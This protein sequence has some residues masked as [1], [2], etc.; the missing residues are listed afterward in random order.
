MVLSAA[1]DRYNNIRR[2]EKVTYILRAPE[3]QHRFGISSI[4]VGKHELFTAGRD[5]TVR[6]WAHPNLD[7]PDAISS[8]QQQQQQQ[9]DATDCAKSFDEHV[10]WVN[11]I[12]L[13]PHHERM[14]SCSSD[15]TLKVWNIN[16]STRS[17][18]TL[19]AHTDYVK[20]LAHA[21]HGVASGSLDGHIYVWDLVTG[22]KAIELCDT[23]NQSFVN[24]KNNMNNK[25]NS[26]ALDDVHRSAPGTAA[27]SDSSIYCMSGNEGGT[28]LVS[29]STDRTISVWDVRVGERVVNLRGHQDSVRCL[30]LKHDSSLMLSGGTDSTVKLWDLRH[31]RCAVSYDSFAGSVWALAPNRELTAFLSGCRDGA[32]WYNDINS[33]A[34]SVV[35]PVADPDPRSNMVLDVALSP[36]KSAAWVS[37]TG[38]AVR[39][40]PLGDDA[41]VAMGGKPDRFR[42][43]FSNEHEHDN[44]ENANSMKDVSSQQRKQQREPCQDL[45]NAKPLYTIP[46]LP[47]IIA[48]RTMNDRRHVLTCDT[49]SE[50]K[51]WDITRGRLEKSLGVIEG[52]DIDAVRT[53]NDIEVSVP[54]WFHVDIRLGSL[55]VRLDKSIVANAEIYAVDAGLDA[56][57]EDVKV[58]IGEHVVIG[59]FRRWLEKYKEREAAHE[60]EKKQNRITNHDNDEKSANY[61]TSS[62]SSTMKNSNAPPTS[63]ASNTTSSSNSARHQNPPTQPSSSSAPPSSSSGG[64]GATKNSGANRSAELPQYVFPAHI[65]VVVTVD[66]SPVP[67][68]R[69]MVGSFNG[70]EGP[71]LPRWV[72]DLVRDGVG[73]C[74]EVV[75]ISFS[76]E[77]VEGC[78]LPALS[79][80]TLNAPRVLRIRKVTAYVSRELRDVRHNL[81]FDIEAEHLEVLCNGLVLPSTMS[82][83]TVRQFKWRAPDDLQ[84]HYRLKAI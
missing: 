1:A 66:Q 68:L 41:C 14:I 63:T 2:D 34:A 31:Q 73:Q 65:P 55:L 62:S 23:S 67:E 35:V 42:H 28:V 18:R 51:I 4:A 53:A 40:W 56:S 64:T 84:L 3:K 32:V 43:H 60:D 83:A 33:S 29:G 72:V 82:L 49:E 81:N 10:D 76:L 52:A 79:T 58:N 77:P 24:P 20:A 75:K 21:Q 22:K 47:G 19:T 74:R 54:S 15:T 6:S 39:L 12:L 11:D 44:A 5:G 78:G 8:L 45:L 69:R 26:S 25:Y 48:H 27:A 9:T 57:S 61:T 17:L 7:S 71:S 50:Y 80:T 46:G 38:S 37:T 36:C 70:T 13:I 59:L 16:D 30:S